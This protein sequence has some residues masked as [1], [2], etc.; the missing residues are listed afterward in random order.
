M[1]CWISY[2]IQKTF[3]NIVDRCFIICTWYIRSGLKMEKIQHQKIKYN[4]HFNSSIL[5]MAKLNKYV[6]CHVHCTQAD[7]SSSEYKADPRS[8]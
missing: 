8:R 2:N 7:Q 5:S 6:I 1:Y 3:V 4:S